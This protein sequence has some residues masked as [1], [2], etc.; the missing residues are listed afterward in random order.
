MGQH[1]H[2]WLLLAGARCAGEPLVTARRASRQRTS[3]SPGATRSGA[4]ACA[5]YAR[6]HRA[7]VVAAAATVLR[8]RLQVD[9]AIHAAHAWCLADEHALAVGAGPVHRTVARAATAA[10]LGTAVALAW[11][12]L[13][14]AHHAARSR[15]A[16]H[17]AR[18]AVKRMVER[19]D[20]TPLAQKPRAAADIGADGHAS[21]ADFF[22]LDGSAARAA[23]QRI[24]VDVHADPIT[25][26]EWRA[27]R[28]DRRGRGIAVQ[29]R[30]VIL[31]AL[32]AAQQEGAD[33][34]GARAP[35]HPDNP[36]R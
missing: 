13:A 26:V 32:R 12:A 11:T 3:R 5:A 15:L 9:A 2:G 22:G 34:G 23:V 29:R 17:A 14:A 19:I 6:D 27:I 8:L 35:Q 30:K 10:T 31:Q 28:R 4:L 1:A 16:A 7:A 21:R 20:A 36:T 24:A 33:P 25:G 18:A